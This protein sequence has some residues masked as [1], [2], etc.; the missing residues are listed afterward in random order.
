MHNAAFLRTFGF[1]RAART[2]PAKYTSAV[3]RSPFTVH[4]LGE[5][6]KV[7]CLAAN[8]HVIRQAMPRANGR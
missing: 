7:A 4:E 5:P 1:L 2:L 3:H 6:L 8:H